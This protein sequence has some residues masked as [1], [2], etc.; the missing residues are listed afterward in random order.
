[1]PYDPYPCSFVRTCSDHIVDSVESEKYKYFGT[2]HVLEQELRVNKSSGSV[3]SIDSSSVAAF[4]S[5]DGV[6]VL[7]TSSNTAIASAQPA[8]DTMEGTSPAN[9]ESQQ[10][11]ASSLSRPSIEQRVSFEEDVNASTKLPKDSTSASDEIIAAPD[12]T[13][14]SSS[15]SSVPP[16][17]QLQTV[18]VVAIDTVNTAGSVHSKDEV[19]SLASMS[20][21]LDDS[22]DR[23]QK[24]KLLMDMR[25]SETI[26]KLAAMIAKKGTEKKNEVQVKAVIK[27]STPI[28]KS[29]YGMD[30]AK[31]RAWSREEENEKLSSESFRQEF[32]LDKM[33]GFMHAIL[34]I[35]KL[36]NWWRMLRSKAKFAEW[37]AERNEIKEKFFCA[38]K[39]YFRAEKMRHMILCG[40][41]FHAWTQ[42]IVD[43][44]RLSKLVGEFFRISIARSRLTP[45][46]VMT[47][48]SSEEVDISEQDRNKIRRLILTRLYRGWQADVK[49]TLRTRYKASAI[50]ARCMRRGNTT[51]WAKE[52]MFL[53]YHTWRRY[54]QVNLAY[55]QDLPIPRFTFPH[56]P[57]W[58]EL[59][60][61]I[62]MKKLRKQRA[63]GN[64]EKLLYI[65]WFRSW[66]K[67]MTVDKA[68]LMTPDELAEH[69]YNLL[70]AKRHLLGIYFI[71]NIIAFIYVYVYVC[72]M[73]SM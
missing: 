32:A 69:H 30:L 23:A 64:Y 33:K 10:S 12:G 49:E 21:S 41:P 71:F 36:Q 73:S 26:Q 4:D 7:E 57:G 59:S 56:I 63:A 14:S 19:G 68:S 61:K 42:E 50:L 17:T 20:V 60:K 9:N 24:E 13:L 8:V 51:L 25:D 34:H 70:V 46:A 67:M 11:A 55:K 37:R 38:W 29:T 16:A 39:I 45:Q 31:L 3:G 40:K 2:E 72:V 58:S 27:K 65:R 15:L 66:Q 53:V 44:K 18:G 62:T 52:N 5:V 6:Q 48:F 28:E 1:M 54:I 47:F 22:Q 35:V 43:E